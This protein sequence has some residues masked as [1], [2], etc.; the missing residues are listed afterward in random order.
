MIIIYLE[1]VTHDSLSV[2]YLVTITYYGYR[3]LNSIISMV[4]LV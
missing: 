4:L 1:L 2:S 3:I